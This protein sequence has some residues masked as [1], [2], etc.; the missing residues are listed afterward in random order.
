MAFKMLSQKQIT[1]AFSSPFSLPLF[2]LIIVLIFKF[3][4]RKSKPKTNL[5]ELPSPPKLPIIGNLHQLGTLPHHSL[6]DLSLKYGNMMLLELGQK[7]TPAL[8][9]SSADVAMEI[10]KNHDIDFGSYGEKWRQKRK[11]CVLELL[12]V[13][14]VKSFQ[15]IRE[16]EV[17]EMVNKLREASSN[18][19]SVNLSEMLVSTTNNIICKSALGRKCE[20]EGNVKELA[21]KVMIHLTTFVVGD[22]FPSLGWI[23]VFSGKIGEF[24]DTFRALD[25][26]FDKVIE[27]R[28]ALKK[29]ENDQFKKK[30]F[31]DILLQLQEDGMLGFELSNNDIKGILMDMFFGGTDT[32]SATLEWAISELMRHP[33]IMKKAQEEVRRVVGHKSKVE[34]IDI[35][36][37]PYLK[38]VV[39]ETLRLRP[40]TP[41]MS[42]RETISSVNLKGHYIPKKTMV[43]VNNWAIQRDPK[44]WENPEEFMPERFEHSQVDFRGQDFQYIPFGF[45]RRGCPGMNFGIAMVEYILASLLYWYDWETNSGKQDIDMSEVFG[46]VVS[47]KEPLHLKPI[48]FSF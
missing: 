5:N 38:C 37:M 36:E 32:T 8:V 13:K 4:L 31:V 30:G 10:M 46:L 44:N 26:L 34:E 42:P 23:D 28:L 9:V 17:E 14:S 39:K 1:E 21:R 16:E 15:V 19:A 24:K 47:K 43:Y 35:N 3:A 22:Y 27:E 11:I 25:D 6:R 20:G 40:A 12:S 41:L 18:S 33:S 29:I 45:G 7:Q 48:A 2:F